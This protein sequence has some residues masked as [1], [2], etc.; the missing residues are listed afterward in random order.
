MLEP[1]YKPSFLE[2]LVFKILV[3]LYPSA[4]KYCGGNTQASLLS[5]LQVNWYFCLAFLRILS[6]F[7]ESGVFEK[8]SQIDFCLVLRVFFQYINSHRCLFNEIF[9]IITLNFFWSITLYVSLDLS[10]IYNIPNGYSALGLYTLFFF[11]HHELYLQPLACLYV[12]VIPIC[13]IPPTP[14]YLLSHS[15]IAITKLIPSLINRLSEC[16]WKTPFCW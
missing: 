11:P 16:F 12:S 15:L 1:L 7:L 14:N 5:S 10:K 3:I 13:S 6:S 9:L 2:Y 8:I 4:V